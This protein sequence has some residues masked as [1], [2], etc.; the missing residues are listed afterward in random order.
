MS[1]N[2]VI[3]VRI[4]TLLCFFTLLTS[5]SVAQTSTID[6]LNYEMQRQKVNSLLD[7]RQARFGQFETSLRSKTGI[8]GLKTKRDMQSSIDILQRIVETDN[9]VFRETK[10]LL[11]LKDQE[12]SFKEYENERVQQL[13]S[14]YDQ[15]I[16]AYIATISKLQQEQSKLRDEVSALRTKNNTFNGLV[17]LFF[18]LV[19]GTGGWLWYKKKYK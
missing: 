12:L 9:E 8:F 16:D 3:S 17:V 13:A 7:Q 15:R 18:V 6:S 1:I 5:I 2:P 19:L 4:F 14:E 11:D 10:K